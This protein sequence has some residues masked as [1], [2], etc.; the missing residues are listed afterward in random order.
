MEEVY[1]LVHSTDQDTK[2]WKELKTGSLDDIQHQFPG[3]YFTLVTKKNI[4]KI[5]LLPDRDKVLIFSKK[6]LEQQNYH[7]NLKDYNGYISEENTYFPWNIDEAIKKI[8]EDEGDVGNEVVFHDPVSM[9]YL[10]STIENFDTSNVSTNVLLPHVPIENSVE[11]DLEKEPFYCFPLERNY[12]G[13]DPI[14]ESSREFFQKMATLCGVKSDL[15]TDKIIEESKKKIR[16][17]YKRRYK[18][19]IN[20]LKPF[21]IKNPLKPFNIKN[22]ITPIDIRPINTNYN[23]KQK[24]FT[25]KNTIKPFTIKNPLKPVNITPITTDYKINFNGKLNGKVNGGKLRKTKKERKTRK[26]KKNRHSIRKR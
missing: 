26:A 3:V 19:N 24:P 5:P 4:D 8:D 6:L 13:I 10:C 18:Q 16:H 23:I 20:V 15:P 14:N 17:L 12:T 21:N 7:I 2:N 22:P 25:I 11:P 1:Y 9:K